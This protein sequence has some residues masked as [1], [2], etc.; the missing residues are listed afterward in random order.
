MFLVVAAAGHL[1]QRFLIQRLL[2]GPFR[3]RGLGLLADFLFLQECQDGI[4][5]D[6]ESCLRGNAGIQFGGFLD[7][8][9]FLSYFEQFLA[10]SFSLSAFRES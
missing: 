1:V 9:R 7:A 5:R 10:T 3:F 6:A 8:G 4:F 2:D